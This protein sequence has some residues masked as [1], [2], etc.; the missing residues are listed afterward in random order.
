MYTLSSYI[1]IPHYTSPLELSVNDLTS[2]AGTSSTTHLTRP[3]SSFLHPYAYAFP[4]SRIFRFLSDM[5]RC[6]SPSKSRLMLVSATYV[7]TAAMELGGR[8]RCG[9]DRLQ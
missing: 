7:I 8:G 9:N 2:S 1:L 4:R 3:P 6:S 5:L